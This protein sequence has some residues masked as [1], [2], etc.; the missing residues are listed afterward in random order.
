MTSIKAVVDSVLVICCNCGINF[1]GGDV[2]LQDSY[3]ALQ[4][5]DARQ[6]LRQLALGVDPR[7]GEPI[8]K[9]DL[10]QDPEVIRAFFLAVEA[11]T[12]H[13]VSAPA[14]TRQSHLRRAG[15]PW[16]EEEDEQLRQEFSHGINIQLI[17]E[18][19]YRTQG[20]IAARLVHL[21]LITRRD[22]VRKL[23]AWSYGTDPD[24]HRT[25]CS[26]SRDSAARSSVS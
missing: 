22:E 19:H 20:A 8:G 14:D 3:E 13:D 25:R 10:L 2:E 24:D 4:R 9:S 1:R 7:S 18:M 16:S 11:L 15:L 12:D 17:T 6:I 21:K 5:N 26:I 23:L